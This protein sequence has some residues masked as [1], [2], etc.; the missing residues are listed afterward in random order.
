M[1]VERRLGKKNLGR[2]LTVQYLKL[3]K[4]VVEDSQKH[5]QLR[6]RCKVGPDNIHPR[7]LQPSEPTKQGLESALLP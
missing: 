7:H 5:D 6:R 3:Y 2:T 4:T 1:E